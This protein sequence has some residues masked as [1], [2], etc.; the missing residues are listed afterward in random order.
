MNSSLMTQEEI[1]FE[2]MQSNRLGGWH[3]ESPYK[4]LGNILNWLYVFGTF[5]MMENAM[6]GENEITYRGDVLAK[7]IWND[8]L[9][10]PMLVVPNDKYKFIEEN[11]RIFIKVLKTKKFVVLEHLTLPDRGF[12]F[13]TMN[14]GNNAHSAL[15]ELWYS[16]VFYTDSIEL[17]SMYAS[18]ASSS[19]VASMRE[20]EIYFKEK[21][22][23]EKTRQSLQH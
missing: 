23:N 20:L 16:P 10:M 21:L 19:K 6:V 11:Q 17:A 13:Y 18:Q 3:R 12:R 14:S 8:D 1:K 5:D 22:I 7:I 9:L 15:G 2:N 4:S